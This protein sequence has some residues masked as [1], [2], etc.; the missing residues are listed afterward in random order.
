MS[1]T[2][3]PAILQYLHHSRQSIQINTEMVPQSKPQ[4]LSYTSLKTILRRF[5]KI[6]KSDYYFRH[7]CLSV[8]PSALNNS[9]PTGRIFIKFGTC[10]F[11]ENLSRKFKFHWNPTRITF[12]LY[13][14]RY[15][16]ML[17][18]P[19]VLLRMRNIS[20]KSSREN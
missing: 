12:T 4:P 18:S 17:V 10:V 13:E 7:F 5:R 20:E 2:Q 1:T 6:A 9:V 15:S 19:S 3:M 16:F 11:F 14:D 8:H